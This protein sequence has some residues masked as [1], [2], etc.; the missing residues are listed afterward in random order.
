MPQMN[1]RDRWLSLDDDE[2]VAQCKVDNYRAS[3][4]G[5]QHRNKVSSAVRLRHEP[6][7]VVAHA[8]E[9]RSQHENKKRA[10]RRLRLEIALNVRAEV[11]TRLTPSGESDGVSGDD[12]AAPSGNVASYEPPPIFLQYRTKAG[13]IEVA[14]KNRDFAPVV[15]AVLDV[16]SARQG[17]M[18]EAAALLGVST[19]QLSRFITNEPPVLRAANRIRE[20]H[21]L[22]HLTADR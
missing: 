21:G 4:P 3:G 7:G 22:K 5:G 9:S 16:L 13:R 1:E 14:T 12:A 2:L 8:E 6:S 15:A 18:K 19:S 20:A 17:S 10:I 11:A